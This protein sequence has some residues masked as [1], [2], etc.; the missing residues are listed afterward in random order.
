MVSD[1][2]SLGEVLSEM[3]FPLVC[4]VTIIRKWITNLR[5]RAWAV[6]G[7]IGVCAFLTF[8]F[9]LISSP[10]LVELLLCA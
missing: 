6:Y 10:E 4:D 5:Y 7:R 9:S 8:L 3:L 1:G 2:V